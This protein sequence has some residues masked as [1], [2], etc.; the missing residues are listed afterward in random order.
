MRETINARIE[1]TEL[2]YEDHG[3]LTAWLFLD[4]GWGGQGFGG[5][6]L[7]NYDQ[8]N[9][10]RV[11]TLVCGHFIMAVLRVVGVTKW[12]D[13][14]GKYIRVDQDS[15]KVYRIGNIIKDEW[16]DPAE[17]FKQYREA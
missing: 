3:L 11:P 4:Y 13:I 2:G 5:Y 17:E 15:G 14:P 8:E 12:E 10:V 16:F 1:R 6:C 7:D 9:R